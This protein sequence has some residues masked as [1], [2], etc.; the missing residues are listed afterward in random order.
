MND[1]YETS[2]SIC[3]NNGCLSYIAIEPWGEQISLQPGDQLHVVGRG[4]KA[5]GFLKLEYERNA[6]FLYA[7]PGSLLSIMLN[8]VVLNTASSAIAAI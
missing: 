2:I 8:G 7:W 6:L 5:A 3:N 4:P 1:Q